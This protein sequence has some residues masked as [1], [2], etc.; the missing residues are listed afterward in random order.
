MVNFIAYL[1]LIR[2]IHP[3]Q[4]DFEEFVKVVVTKLDSLKLVMR[5]GD[6]SNSSENIYLL[7]HFDNA[8]KL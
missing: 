7:F 8:K 2:A 5:I 1:K 6:R 4:C 3:Y